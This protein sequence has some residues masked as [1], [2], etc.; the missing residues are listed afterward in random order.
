MKALVNIIFGILMPWV[1]F[2]PWFIL[3][4]LSSAIANLSFSLDEIYWVIIRAAY[5]VPCLVFSLIMIIAVISEWDLN[6]RKYI[7]E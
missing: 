5:G 6:K 4:Y 1:L 2:S 7:W 3:L